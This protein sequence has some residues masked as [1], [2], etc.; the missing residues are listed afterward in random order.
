MRWFPVLL[1]L[2]D[3]LTTILAFLFAYTVRE[4]GVLR[5]FLDGVQP[6]SVYLTVLPIAVALL[7]L[8]LY[9]RGMYSQ[10][11]RLTYAGEVRG[12][13]KATFYWWLLL[14]ALS[15]LVKYDYSRVVVGL[16]FLSTAVLVSLA[17]YVVRDLHLRVIRRTGARHNVLIVG[18]GRVGRDVARR[19]H[20]YSPFG[21]TVIGF[22]DDEVS[23]RSA[24]ALLGSLADLPV[25]I[26][27]YAVREVYIAHPNLSHE[28]VLELMAEVEHLPVRFRVVSNLF[29]LAAGSVDL[30]DL[31]TI[32]SIDVA[33]ASPSFLSRAVKRVVDLVGAVLLFVLLFPLALVC[34]VLI[35]LS[36]PGPIILCQE[37]IGYHAF[38]FRLYKFRTMYVEADLFA[39]P[40]SSSQDPRITPIGR[41]LRKTSL[42]ELPQLMNVLKGEMSLVGPRPEMP[43]K[44][45]EYRLWQRK[46]FAVKPG[47]TGLWQILGRKDLPLD[48]NLEYDFYYIT[49]QSLLLDLEILVRTIPVVLFGRGAY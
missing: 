14:M 5:R 18:A 2:S 25:L 29:D 31:E 27:E 3:I 37:R 41:W 30:Y 38:P 24:V 32:P 33:K 40:P 21:Y 44:V 9:A 39:E 7:I 47:L 49:N 1:L 43:Y 28:A 23:A 15:Y 19:L 46:R 20:R 35:R 10:K 11:R 42:D 17:R 13:V 45:K 12:V 8:T 22:V 26:R 16:F 4:Y 6:L 48:Q 34:G 36:S